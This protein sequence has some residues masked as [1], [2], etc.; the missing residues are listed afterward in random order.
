MHAPRSSHDAPSSSLQYRADIDG[1]RAVSIVS[2]V[3]YHVGL[4]YVSGGFVGVDVFFVI[5]G[6]LITKIVAAEM[7]HGTFSF[8]RFYERRARRLL[9]TLAVVLAACFVVGL[10]V[11]VPQDFEEFAHSMFYTLIF[12]ANIFF[13]D[14]GGYFD[15]SLNLAPLL[16]FWSLAVEEQFYLVWPLVLLALTR[17]LP[18]RVVVAVAVLIALSFL[19][20]VTT[21]DDDA[22]A[23]F[24]M[25]HTRAWELL[26]GCILALAAPRL[27]RAVAHVAGVLGLALIMWAVLN[28]DHRV[29]Y[30]GFWALVPTLGA[31][32][33][34]WSGERGPS[35][36]GRL[37]SLRPLVFIGLVSYAWYL[38]HWPAIA[39]FRY[40][41]GREPAGGEIAAMIAIP[42]VLAVLS[43]AYLEKPIRQRTWWPD[44]K[45]AI[46]AGFAV[47][48]SLI[49]IS[50]AGYLSDGFIHRFPAEMQELARK[51]LR[52]KMET[53]CVEA[54]AD[55]IARDEL[56]RV[57]AENDDVPGVLL[58]GDSH[59]RVLA[60]V[61]G[62]IAR[63]GK[64]PLIY[65]GLTSCPPLIGIERQ[66]DI[67]GFHDACED[68][69][70]AVED[71]LQRHKFTDVVL[72]ARWNYYLGGLKAD[73]SPWGEQPY[74]K[75]T[76]RAGGTLADNRLIFAEAFK[77][78]ID[79]IRASGASVWIV[80]EAP[81]AE[82]D[83]P[84]Q[85]ARN[86][87]RGVPQDTMF[88]MDLTEKERRDRFLKA[89]IGNLSARVIDP[90]KNL[91]ANGRCVL[92][93]QGRPLYYDSNHLSKHGAAR[94]A[95]M[96]TQVFVETNEHE[97]TAAATP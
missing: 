94:I 11:M 17:Y 40:E 50:G 6:Y 5:S 63:E 38:W 68:L 1:L 14:R 58:W 15:P 73:G 55:A 10:F 51:K 70:R 53:G 90:A 83:V 16:H 88:G 97:P 8:S 77:R 2:V 66:D 12:T 9:P 95:P 93:E 57:W 22:R 29:P 28:L 92:V 32:L 36:V 25:P 86:M 89:A 45:R 80:S 44:R 20:N 52:Q 46:R 85:M 41:F 69:N 91:C 24:Y 96:F 75:D 81:F 87:M 39:F 31:V 60:P 18:G 42:F 64:V 49:A 65:T 74:F 76:T 43:W 7:R 34:I 71:L 84:L 3:L 13:A 19:A 56:C 62:N 79:V 47:S 48:L 82:F 78:T 54:S 21:L 30:P 72:A 67:A 61:F 27:G 23:A 35:L 37:L 4:P 33:V 59:A 26:L